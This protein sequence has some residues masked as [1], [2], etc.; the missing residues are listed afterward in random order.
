MYNQLNFFFF[1]PLS[2]SVVMKKLKTEKY[3]IAYKPNSLVSHELNKHS[4]KYEQ[5]IKLYFYKLRYE[6]HGQSHAQGFLI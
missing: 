6:R 5:N 4:V 2:L 1:F 3:K